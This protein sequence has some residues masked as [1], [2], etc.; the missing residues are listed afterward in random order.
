MQELAST[1]LV[2]DL[3]ADFD[4]D[5]AVRLCSLTGEVK[6]KATADQEIW[7]SIGGL[8][9]IYRLCR[10][11]GLLMRLSDLGLRPVESQKMRDAYHA[12]MGTAPL[13]VVECL[14]KV[15]FVIPRRANA[16]AF[17]ELFAE[18]FLQSEIIIS[19]IDARPGDDISC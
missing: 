13:C 12:L 15:F 19:I 9:G 11:A 10:Q 7:D 16:R 18:L 4:F 2:S 3:A 1:R 5:K 8:P 6:L 17:A 14:M